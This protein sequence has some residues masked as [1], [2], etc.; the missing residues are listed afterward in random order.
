MALVAR[1]GLDCA[2]RRRVVYR[3]E[4]PLDAS[5]GDFLPGATRTLTAFSA[6]VEG[7]RDHLRLTLGSHVE[8]SFVIGGDEIVVAYG[9]LGGTAPE[10][11][12]AAVESRLAERFGPIASRDAR[13]PRA[14]HERA[15]R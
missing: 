3:A 13:E 14:R 15:D 12:I 6:V 1:P 9:K 11:V 5:D 4:R 10:P 2:T 7:A 8:A